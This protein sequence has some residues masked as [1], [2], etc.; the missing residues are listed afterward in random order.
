MSFFPMMMYGTAVGS[1][2]S[3][4]ISVAPDLAFGQQQMG[5]PSAPQV[6]TI[7]NTGSLPLTVTYTLT[8]NQAGNAFAPGTPAPPNGAH[9]LAPGNAEKYP[10]VCKPPGVGQYTGTLAASTA[11]GPMGSSALSCSGV[12]SNLQI[13]PSPA[14]FG[15]TYVGI[16]PSPITVVISS[17]LTTSLTGISLDSAA[18]TAGVSIKSMNNTGMFGMG[19]NATIVLAWN[20]AAPSVLQLG[21]LT[22]STATET[23]T[24]P[25]TG[26]AAPGSISTNP[27]SI[28][29]GPVCRNGM[30]SAMLQVYAS[31]VADV[32]LNGAAA[33][34][35]PFQ[36]VTTG[37]MFPYTLG[38]NHTGDLMLP[39]Q[40]VVG[41]NASLGDVMGTADLMTDLPGS[42]AT[43]QIMLHANVLAG[44][45]ATS[46]T[47]LAFGTTPVLTATSPKMTTLANCSGGDLMVT[48]AAIQGPDAGSFVL[49][50]PDDQHRMETI[51]NT[52][53]Q[54]YMIVMLPQTK[55]AKSA[56]LEVDFMGG[57]NMVVNLTGSGG[58][59][60]N[61]TDRQTY[62][63]C[64]TGQPGA[65]WPIAAACGVLVL[66]RRRRGR[67]NFCQPTGQGGLSG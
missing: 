57:S 35:A 59:D 6:V 37:I 53:S 51:M 61:P 5:I 11:E 28:D 3:A 15:N 21:N 33:S 63:A 45:V 30:G 55:G 34:A 32:K 58:A 52:T 22:L 44:G 65:L 12:N 13:S 10:I 19:T 38:G 23:R 26:T 50:S 41:A 62:Y 39:V 9:G 16:A 7:T 64:S 67:C 2:G 4:S 49:L 24:V 60:S 14:P 56:Y 40:V 29:F 17:A 8:N 27:A 54:A 48:G 47:S 46:P 25:I 36:V 42:A 1:N 20:A 66:R 31:D 18:I 43:D